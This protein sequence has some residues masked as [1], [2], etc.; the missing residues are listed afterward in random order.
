MALEGLSPRLANRSLWLAQQLL[1]LL[2]DFPAALHAQVRRLCL[3]WSRPGRLDEQ[4]VVVS[5]EAQEWLLRSA[6]QF[7]FLVEMLLQVDE[8]SLGLRS[9]GLLCC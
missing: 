8:H 3:P 4:I 7:G 2:L 6:V 5:L 9:L 1:L